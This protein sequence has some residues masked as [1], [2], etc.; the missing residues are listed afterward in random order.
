MNRLDCLKKNKLIFNLINSKYIYKKFDNF[1][2]L[3]F[4]MIFF[5]IFFYCALACWFKKIKRKKLLKA[6]EKL[7]EIIC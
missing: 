3:L 4:L 1:L 2:K 5:L 7:K 6:K